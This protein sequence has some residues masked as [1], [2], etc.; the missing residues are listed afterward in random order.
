M[1]QQQVKQYL[2]LLEKKRALA[3]QKMEEYKNSKEYE[4]EKQS[5]SHIERELDNWEIWNHQE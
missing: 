3:K 1:T 4:E 5:I 2:A